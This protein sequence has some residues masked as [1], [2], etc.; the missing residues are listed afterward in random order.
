MGRPVPEDGMVIRRVTLLLLA[1]CSV[2]ALACPFLDHPAA[3]VIFG[4]A[5]LAFPALLIALGAVRHGRIGFLIV[6]LLLL[7]LLLEG[8]FILMLVLSGRPDPAGWWLGLPP[9]TVVMF[10]GLWLVPLVLVSLV[11][12]W[13]FERFGL[14]EG[15]LRRIRDHARRRVAGAAGESRDPAPEQ[16]G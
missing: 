2:L 9:A 16:R 3:G 6:P 4:L 5:V 10:L 12:A 13:H 14:T 15:D 7:T 11:Y 1:L 8:G